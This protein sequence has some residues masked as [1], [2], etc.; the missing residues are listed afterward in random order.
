MSGE[1]VYKRFLIARHDV[2]GEKFIGKINEERLE[3]LDKTK[4]DLRKT[5]ANVFELVL[6][7]G[8]KS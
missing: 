8:G 4:E 6:I 7:K 2:T 3:Y 5:G 1:L